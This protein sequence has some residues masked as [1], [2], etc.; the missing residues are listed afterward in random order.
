MH[1]DLENFHN[2][3]MNIS[4]TH[5]ICAGNLYNLRKLM[6]EYPH[7]RAHMQIRLDR[8]LPIIG[9][10]FLRHRLPTARAVAT[11]RTGQ[12]CCSK[13]HKLQKIELFLIVKL[14]YNL[15]R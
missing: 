5:T 4:T 1:K 14:Y 13:I 2:S 10:H 8:Q 3:F 15:A 12:T 6:Q 7:S 11:F 9:E